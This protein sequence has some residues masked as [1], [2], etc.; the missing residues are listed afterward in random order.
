M[1]GSAFFSTKSKKICS[2]LAPGYW[3][4][5][6]CSYYLEAQAKVSASFRKFGSFS[7]LKVENNW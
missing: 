7:T 3:S 1:D 4:S 6:S 2:I 5:I